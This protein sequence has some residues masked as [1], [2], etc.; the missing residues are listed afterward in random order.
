MFQNLL[1]PENF[2][3]VFVFSLFCLAV[4]LFVWRSTQVR[5]IAVVAPGIPFGKLLDHE[6]ITFR[7]LHNNSIIQHNPIIQQFEAAASLPIRALN[8]IQLL[9]RI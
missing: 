8:Q 9:K 5:E 2:L 1:F 6:I 3:S 4:L 7:Y